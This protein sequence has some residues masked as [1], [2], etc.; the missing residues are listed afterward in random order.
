MAK[1]AILRTGKLKSAASVKGMLKHNFRTIETPNADDS[2]TPDNEHLAAVSVE[3]GMRRYREVLPDKVRKN[4]VHAIDYMITT[5]QG[6]TKKAKEATMKEAYDWIAEK[7]GKENIIMAS[8]HRDETTPHIHIVVIPI[9][10][11]GKLNARHFTGGT[12]HRMSELQDEFYDRLVSK[13]IDIDRGLKGSRAKH[14]SI[15]SWHAKKN[16]VDVD[17]TVTASRI[18]QSLERRKKN[19]FIK[20]KPEEAN[21][22]VA[23]AIAEIITSQKQELHDANERLA[24]LNIYK[25]SHVKITELKNDVVNGNTKTLQALLSKAEQNQERRKAQKAKRTK[26]RSKNQYSR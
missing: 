7:H 13:K 2:L 5:S 25:Q 24:H 6:A 17:N 21:K 16:Q 1:F 22:R 20:E 18:E 8:K 3:D 23:E 4:A 9:D 11:K 14:Q 12:K 15:K 26:S 10:P 19:A